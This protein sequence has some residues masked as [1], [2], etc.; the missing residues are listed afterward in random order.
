MKVNNRVEGRFEKAAN[1]RT[2]SSADTW[3]E[4]AE[5]ISKYIAKIVRRIAAQSNIHTFNPLDPKSIVRVLKI[6]KFVRDKNAVQKN[7]IG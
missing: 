4:Y 6:F 3:T 7:V 1:Y 5:L 2:Y